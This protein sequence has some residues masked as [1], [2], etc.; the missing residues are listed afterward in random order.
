MPL[1]FGVDSRWAV[2]LM[3][4][5]RLMESFTALRMAQSATMLCTTRMVSF[6]EE[7]I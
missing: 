1:R 4:A 7:W 2:H 6:F 3:Q 5:A